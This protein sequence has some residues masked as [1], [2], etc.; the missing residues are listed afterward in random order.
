MQV[1]APGVS[2]R[3]RYRSSAAGKQ[4]NS[5]KNALHPCWFQFAHTDSSVHV[6]SDIGHPLWM[7]TGTI[8][9][10]APSAIAYALPLVCQ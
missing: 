9:A 10:T 1:G 7:T 5:G 3:R 4:L 8:L 6:M 2:T